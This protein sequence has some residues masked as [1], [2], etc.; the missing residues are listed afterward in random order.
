MNRRAVVADDDPTM[1]ELV[2]LDLE[3]L[4]IEVVRVSNG[5][6]L[7]DFVANRGP[8]D[9]IVTDISMPWMSGLQVT[10]SARNAGMSTPIIIITGLTRPELMEQARNLGGSTMVLH[11]PFDLTELEAAVATV[12]KPS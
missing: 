3:H 10:R 1:L 2:A 6:D 12:L 9:L 11:K 5:A 8:F 7:I 4:G